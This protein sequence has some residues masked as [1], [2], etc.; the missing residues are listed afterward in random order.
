MNPEFVHTP[1]EF[2]HT[3]SELVHNPFEPISSYLI[4]NSTFL[5]GQFILIFLTWSIVSYCPN[6]SIK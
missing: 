4:C 6:Y 2:V 1:C 3:P 5:S